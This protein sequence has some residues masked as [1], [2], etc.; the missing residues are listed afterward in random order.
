MPT[1]RDREPLGPGHDDELVPEDDTVIGKAFRWS[2][3]VIVVAVL[4]VVG[5]WWLTREETPVEVVIERGEV[6]VPAPLDQGQ[7]MPEVAKI[8]VER[9]RHFAE[10]EVPF[11]IRSISLLG[12]AIEE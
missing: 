8:E 9:T 3:V 11:E 5:I 10:Y 6:A 12:R 7:A 2:L 4:V 1:E